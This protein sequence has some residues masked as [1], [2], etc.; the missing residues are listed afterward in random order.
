MRGSLIVSLP[1]I[2]GLSDRFWSKVRQEGDCWVWTGAL[3][4]G[5]YGR[6][7]VG[8][9]IRV[10]HRVAYLMLVGDIPEGLTLDHLCKTRACVN[11]YHLDPVPQGVNASRKGPQRLCKFGHEMAKTA[12][13]PD[14]RCKTC[15]NEYHKLWQRAYRERKISK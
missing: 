2:P 7:S 5:G 4:K 11:P 14:R 10:P 3:T 9:E 15:H 1:S 12:F 13:G 8:G 6:F